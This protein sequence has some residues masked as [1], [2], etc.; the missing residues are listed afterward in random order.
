MKLRALSV[1]VVLSMSLGACT[2]VDLSQV[3]IQSDS[4]AVT[5]VKQNVVERASAALTSKFRSKGW[6][7][8][9]PQEKTQTAASVLLNGVDSTAIEK[10][11]TNIK[12]SSEA[13][14]AA[15]L[16]SANEHIVQATKAAEVFL[17]ISEDISDVDSELS[18][19]ET[20]LLSAKEAETR[21]EKAVTSTG[22]STVR[23]NFEDLQTSVQSL[24]KVTDRY[25]D[26]ARSTIVNKS[27]ASRS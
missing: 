8:G 3:A 25:G 7:A 19:L 17:S 5:P 12:F 21:F 10:R 15:E 9:G 18:L 13:H 14:L 16:V 20:A 6:C 26:R 2:T 1:V 24:K 11:D 22:S 23:Q 4:S 27:N